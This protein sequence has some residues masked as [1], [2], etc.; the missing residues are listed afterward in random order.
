MV[1]KSV[2][3]IVLFY[4]R[5]QPPHSNSGEY[6]GRLCVGLREVGWSMEEMERGNECVDDG[7]EIGRV[8][9]DVLR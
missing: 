4:I 2:K 7:E 1:R 5:M 9:G 3:L 6:R 8:G